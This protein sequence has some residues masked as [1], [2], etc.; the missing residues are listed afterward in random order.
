MLRV[1]CIRIESYLHKNKN[2][3]NRL[4][5]GYDLFFGA[6]W[7][8]RSVDPIPVLKKVAELRISALKHLKKEERRSTK[9]F[10]KKEDLQNFIN[11]K[12]SGKKMEKV[13]VQCEQ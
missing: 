11:E 5:H 13:K 9:D 7:L 1:V 4:F 10:Q 8:I 2:T 3:A 6:I 12:Y